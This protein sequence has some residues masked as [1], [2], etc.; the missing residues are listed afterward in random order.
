MNHLSFESLQTSEVRAT[1]TD[2]AATCVERARDIARA[3]RRLKPEKKSMR[4]LPAELDPRKQGEVDG[5][6][7]GRQLTGKQAGSS[8][9]TKGT[10]TM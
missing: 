5:G 2:K 8:G 9:L 7:A 4:E 3:V 10:D 6:G 1:G